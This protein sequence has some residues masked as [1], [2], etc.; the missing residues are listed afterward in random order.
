MKVNDWESMVLT[1]RSREARAV[2]VHEVHGQVEG[3]E[4]LIADHGDGS[5]MRLER[6]VGAGRPYVILDM[7]PSS[8]GGYPVFR[9]KSATGAPVLRL[10]YSDRYDYLV[11]DANGEFGDFKRGSCKYLGVELPVPPANPYRYELYTVTR[12]GVYAFPLVQ[13]QQRW[14]R[15]QL[16]TEDSA[17]E[18]ESFHLVGVSDMQPHAGHFLA[19][20]EDITMLWYASTYTAQLAS[21]DNADAWTVIAGWLAPRGLA[22]ADEVGLSVQGSSW[23]DY[24]FSFE[25]QIMHNPGPVSAV[26]WVV[27][28]A[29]PRN[30]YA[31]ALDLDARL[32]VR[33]RREGAYSYLK[34]AIELP[35][36]IAAGIVDCSIHRIRSVVVGDRFETWLDG[37]LVD[38]TH[39]STIGSGCVGFS[40][41]LD[42]WALVRDV[43]VVA[44]PSEAGAESRVLLED[45]FAQGLDKWSFAKTPSFVAD[46]AKRDRLPWI[47]D[48]DWAGRNI[49]YAFRNLQYM[50]DSLELFA[51]N[52]TPEG[53]VWAAC[54]P[55]NTRRPS[56]GEYGYYQSDLFSA[57][58]IPTVA[59]YVL[60]AGDMSFARSIYPSV[61][62]DAD[63][64]WSYVEGDGLHYQRY[65]TSKGLWSHELEDIGKFAYNNILVWDAMEEAA[66]IA[67]FIGDDGGAQE[68]RDRAG[69][70]RAAILRA[71]WDDERGCFV[72]KL[73]S[74]EPCFMANS[75]ALATRLLDGDHATRIAAYLE[76]KTF[77]HGKI[78]SLLIRGLYE[79]GCDEMAIKRLRQPGG[80]VNWLDAIKDWKSPMTTTECQVFPFGNHSGQNWGDCSHPDTAMAHILSGYMLGVRPT[81]P[82]FVTFIVEPHTAGLDWATGVVPT[83]SGN[84]AFN[85]ESKR[86]QDRFLANLTYP[87]G[88]SATLVM[89]TPMSS[90][91]FRVL[92]SG[93]VVYDTKTG[94]SSGVDGW[95]T[96]DRIYLRGAGVGE[97]EVVCV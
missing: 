37:V 30:C 54:Y 43:R 20:D 8:P 33:L 75:L 79:N 89:P 92:H 76:D 51:F 60:F 80:G 49:Y 57:W 90:R 52:Q 81:S 83:P 59:D 67:G 9:V 44:I 31:F 11:D 82:G 63:Y 71:F 1:P 88:L 58:Y 70:M 35:A 55:E 86:D 34:P 29:D 69:L 45:D 72:G 65:D 10:A 47:G 26:G 12:T 28:A 32:H 95:T 78:V 14:V 13:G 36:D 73:G 68:L 96:D 84:I 23:T 56:I 42:K 3:A 6:P 93:L 39:D 41:P 64:L 22:K 66:F 18:L 74:V 16:D 61:K 40:Q 27:R 97:Y 5:A 4:S 50:R 25:F 19:S 85:W 7:G 15:I 2:A 77:Y 38:V 53:Y 94:F 24:E 48:L 62:A 21:I 46:G 17:V 91:E 87:D